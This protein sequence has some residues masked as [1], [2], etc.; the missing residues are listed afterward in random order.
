MSLLNLVWTLTNTGGCVLLPEPTAPNVSTTT[1]PPSAMAMG[2]VKGAV[3]C[4]AL[5]V[6]GAL[7]T[8]N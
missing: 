7:L 2:L 6:V 1:T 3:S 4:L 8:F 5:W